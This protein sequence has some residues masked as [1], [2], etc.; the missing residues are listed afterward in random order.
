MSIISGL[1][2][3][4]NRVS[5][6]VN[7]M[8]LCHTCNSLDQYIGKDSYFWF[9]VNTL[10]FLCKIKPDIFYCLYLNTH[11]SNLVFSLR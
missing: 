6:I 11:M 2:R 8:Q 7:L 5:V 3:T 10:K 9:F 4:G 1:F